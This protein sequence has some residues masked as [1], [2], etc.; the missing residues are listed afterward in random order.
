L[1]ARKAYPHRFSIGRCIRA[2]FSVGLLM[3][4]MGKAKSK[5][6]LYLRNGLA[7][8]GELKGMSLGLVEFDLDGIQLVN[9]K[10]NKIKSLYASMHLFRVQTTHKHIYFSTIQNSS[11]AG[12]VIISTQA[13]ADTLL[14]ENISSITYFNIG[15][16][17]LWEG[18]VSTGYSFT[19]SSDI[20]RFNFDATINYKTQKNNMGIVV[21]TIT[22]QENDTWN[23]DREDFRI[24]DQYYLNGLFQAFG[25][26][27]YQRNLEL[28]L[29]RRFQEGLGMGV[30]LW[31]KTKARGDLLTGLVANQ[32]LGTDGIEQKIRFELPLVFSMH[33]FS[34]A[35]PDISISISQTAFFD[36]SGNKRIR[37]DGDIRINWK[38]FSDFGV[39]LQF[40]DNF[41]SKSP[42]TGQSNVDYGTVFGL[43]Y[44]FP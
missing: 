2:A 23:R 27:S 11:N 20:G 3:I 15:K 12:E 18:K 36:V 42:G 28:G 1:I 38:V 21:S 44:K 33:V 32:D 24:S 31:A 8:A 13:G 43:T 29:A 37:Q 22:T 26:V 19:K 6:T 7:V 25:V 5:D 35:K 17:G 14:L 9:V 4:T 16:R 40:Y 30:N 34:F 10:I 39:S 41:D